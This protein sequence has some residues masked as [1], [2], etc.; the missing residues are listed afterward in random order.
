MSLGGH[1]LI[2]IA[3]TSD[4]PRVHTRIVAFTLHSALCMSK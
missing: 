3:C 1:V 2:V 4:V